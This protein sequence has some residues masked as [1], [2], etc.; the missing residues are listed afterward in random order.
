MTNEA[1]LESVLSAAFSLKHETD[2]KKSFSSLVEAQ[3]E[4]KQ[5]LLT[6][7]QASKCIRE[8][9]RGRFA[10]YDTA[11]GDPLRPD[12]IRSRFPPVGSGSA[13]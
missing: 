12:D 3:D 8:T 5:M 4:A 11:R 7:E 10:L 2:M 9:P 1:G 6:P 13:N